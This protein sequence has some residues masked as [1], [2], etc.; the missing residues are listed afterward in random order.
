MTPSSKLSPKSSIHQHKVELREHY[1][2]EHSKF[3][4][5]NGAS[6]ADQSNNQQ[7]QQSQQNQKAFVVKNL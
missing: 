3:G 4:A 6:I 7:N 5:K 2:I 1:I